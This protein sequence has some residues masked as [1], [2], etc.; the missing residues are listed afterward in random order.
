MK[1]LVFHTAT[2]TIETM[3]SVL[4]PSQLIG[5]WA[6]PAWRTTELNRP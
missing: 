5:R 3:A 2:M 6:S 1:E 4:S